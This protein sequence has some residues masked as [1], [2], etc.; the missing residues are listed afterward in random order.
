MDE[1]A[2]CPLCG[3][4]NSPMGALGKLIHYR[5]RDCGIQFSTIDPFYEQEQA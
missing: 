2:V 1:D 5:C 4:T 3:A